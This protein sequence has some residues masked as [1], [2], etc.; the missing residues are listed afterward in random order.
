MPT[1]FDIT[2]A[3]PIPGAPEKPAGGVPIPG[4]DVDEPTFQ[5]LVLM[6]A[7]FGLN[8]FMKQMQKMVQPP[9]PPAGAIGPEALAGGAPVNQ[10]LASGMAQGVAPRVGT[11]SI[12]GGSLVPQRQ[13]A[14]LRPLV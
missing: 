14:R 2:G 4:L 6:L 5:R 13:D 8:Q 1:H 9:Q 3:Q 12:G 10:A 11:G 7:G